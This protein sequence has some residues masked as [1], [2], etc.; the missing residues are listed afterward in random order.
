M[1]KKCVS[2]HLHHSYNIIHNEYDRKRHCHANITT[3]TM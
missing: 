2:F 3:T 1:I